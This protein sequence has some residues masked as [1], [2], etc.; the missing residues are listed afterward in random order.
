MSQATPTDP[1]ALHD[2]IEQTRAD[3]GETVEALAAK[4]DVKARTKNA[5]D[6]A[7][8]QAM[9]AVNDASNRATN[10]ARAGIGQA[11]RVSTELAQR[12]KTQGL[13]VRRSVRDS[14]LPTMA[15]RPTA[16]AAI[17]SLATVVVAAAWLVRRRR[18]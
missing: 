14:N 3:L 2:E 17:A 4:V 7:R 1:S 16:W 10:H 11:K 18:S 5:M 12:A 6:Q 13:V 9:T 8:S 15:T